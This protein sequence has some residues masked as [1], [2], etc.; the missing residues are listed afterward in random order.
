MYI[1]LV[2]GHSVVTTVVSDP[3][4]GSSL[5]GT[6]SESR[7]DELNNTSRFEC[8]MTELSVIKARDSKASKQVNHY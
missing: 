5:S 4:K 1:T 3:P 2:V 8:V 7:S 6:S